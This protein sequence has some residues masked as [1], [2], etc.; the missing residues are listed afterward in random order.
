MS[1]RSPVLKSIV[2][3]FIWIFWIPAALAEQRVAVLEFRGVGIDENILHKLSDQTRRAATETLPQ[4]EYI[5]LTRENILMILDDMGKDVS[6][7]EGSCEVEI[8]RNIGS[9]LLVTGNILKIEQHYS[10]TLTLYRTQD[11][12]VLGM[13]EI[14][15]EN[16]L[17]LTKQTHLTSVSLFTE[18]LKLSTGD[19]GSDS[20]GKQKR[21]AYNWIS[22]GLFGLSGVNYGLSYQTHQAYLE[23]P[24]ADEAENIFRINQITT[25]GSMVCLGLSG[26]TYILG[27]IRA[28]EPGP[29]RKE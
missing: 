29:G 14:Y 24:D 28:D 3:L 25:I 2:L 13:K 20:Q 11:G 4:Q 18:G 8:G 23:T 26:G 17:E 22:A 1:K 9:D 10:L 15:T 16:L 19:A 21:R 7:F 6:C 12:S 5:I 27:R